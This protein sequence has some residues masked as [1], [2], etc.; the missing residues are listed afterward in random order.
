MV[1][2]LDCRQRRGGLYLDVLDNALDGDCVIILRV[3]YFQGS[4]VELVQEALNRIVS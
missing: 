1:L 2:A 4:L 3:Q